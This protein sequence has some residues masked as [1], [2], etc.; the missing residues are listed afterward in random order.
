VSD[1]SATSATIDYS[2]LG[3]AGNPFVSAEGSGASEQWVRLV[4]N[5]G[6]NRLLSASVRARARSC[7]V[8]VTMTEDIPDYYPRLAL[9]DFLAR[10]A[11]EPALGMMALNIP[12]DMMRLGRIRGTLAELAELVVAVDMPA[13]LAAW[14]LKALAEPGDDL[15]EASLVSADQLAEAARL[16]SEDPKAAVQRYLGVD[17]ELLSNAE[18]DVVIHEAYERQVAQPVEVE[19][20]EESVEAAALDPEEPGTAEAAESGD[21][22]PSADGEP[23][24]ADGAAKDQRAEDAN[25]REYLLVLARTRLSPIVARAL[26]AYGRYGESMAAQ[27]LKIT[28]APRKT[29]AAVLRLMGARWG[30]VVVMYDNFEAWRSLDQQTKV[31]VLASLMELRYIIAESGVMVV[32]VVEGQSPEIAEQ[33]AAG[34]QVDWRMP[35]LEALSKGAK[36]F[37]AAWVQSWL[38]AASLAG[39]SPVKADGPELTPLLE[40][41]GGGIFAFADMAEAAFRDAAGRS[42]TAI[43][44]EAVAAGLAACPKKEDT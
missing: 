22:K 14:Y 1:E 9:N 23:V 35:E 41:S 36:D 19:T 34:E 26:L 2:S 31:E 28:K 15:P 6:A 43:D 7:P 40:A 5:S 29:L 10:V 17:A 20:D 12:L 44:G 11:G 38:D 30:N 13:T 16:L 25:V 32:G 8:L 37:E 3:F 39:V 4:A 27:E 21:A 18:M 42:A 24:E 33:F